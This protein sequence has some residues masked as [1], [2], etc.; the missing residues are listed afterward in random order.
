LLNQQQALEGFASGR[1][2]TQGEFKA[3]LERKPAFPNKNKKGEAHF[4][5]VKEILER[6]LYAGYIDVPNW[7]IKLHPAKHEA[8][9]S[10]ETWKKIQN[11]L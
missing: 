1:F 6:P 4:K 7:D 9:I 11:R 10:F 8:I 3:F 5:T 2:A